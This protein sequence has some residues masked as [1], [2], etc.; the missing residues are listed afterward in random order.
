MRA[1]C[2]EKSGCP[3][4]TAPD[5]RRFGTQASGVTVGAGPSK[6]GAGKQGRWRGPGPVALPPHFLGKAGPSSA[7]V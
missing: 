7:Q 1:V 3:A 2:R 6:A 5:M 4:S